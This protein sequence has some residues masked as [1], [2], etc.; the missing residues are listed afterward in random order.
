MKRESVAIFEE[1]DVY[2]WD[3]FPSLVNITGEEYPFVHPVAVEVNAGGA[4]TRIDR[5]GTHRAVGPAFGRGVL[6][7]IS[8]REDGTAADLVLAFHKGQT[9]ARVERLPAV[10]PADVATIWRD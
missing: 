10:D 1:S 7:R 8:L 6:I 9:Y 3:D 4:I 5:A 2:Q